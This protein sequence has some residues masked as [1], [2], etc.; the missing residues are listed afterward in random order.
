VQLHDALERVGE[1]RPVFRRTAG[2][3]LVLAVIGVRQMVDA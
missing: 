3:S 1:V 2:E